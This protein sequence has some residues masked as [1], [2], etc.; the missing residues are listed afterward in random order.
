MA[1][2]NMI[3]H[4]ASLFRILLKPLTATALTST[5]DRCSPC[6]SDGG[7]GPGGGEGGA[8]DGTSSGARGGAADEG[9]LVPAAVVWEPLVALLRQGAECEPTELIAAP[10]R[11]VHTR[12]EGPRSSTTFLVHNVFPGPAP[13][14]AFHHPLRR[15]VAALIQ[16]L[17]TSTAG[18]AHLEAL[19]DVLC[20]EQVSLWHSVAP[21][22][23]AAAPLAV[24]EDGEAWA[25]AARALPSALEALSGNTFRLHLSLAEVLLLAPLG[26]LAAVSA[27][28]AGVWRRN[29]NCMLEQ[30]MNY[31]SI[32]PP[33]CRQMADLDCHAVQIGATQLS[34]A[35]VVCQV[36]AAFGHFHLVDA[37]VEE[38]SASTSSL[39]DRLLDGRALADVGARVRSPIEVLAHVF[40]SRWPPGA[41]ADGEVAARYEQRGATGASLDARQ[42]SSMLEDALHTILKLAAHPPYP[43]GAEPFASAVEAAVIHAL[44]VRP[45]TYSE[46]AEASMQADDEPVDDSVLRA[47]LSRVA[48]TSTA[49]GHSGGAAGVYVLRDKLAAR[50]YSLAYPHLSRSDH[51]AAGEHIEQTLRRP[52]TDAA[53]ERAPPPQV[54]PAFASLRRL[55]VQP[56]VLRVARALAILALHNAE[57]E[58]DTSRA[59][60]HA[61]HLLELAAHTVAEPGYDPAARAAFWSEWLWE[62]GAALQPALG[63]AAQP[64]AS[65]P[66]PSNSPPRGPSLLASLFMLIHG[67]RCADASA[68]GDSG[69][70]GGGGSGGG[71]ALTLC[72]L[73][74]AICRWLLSQAA[75]GSDECA[76]ALRGYAGEAGE[77]MGG[78][79]SREA[80]ALRAEK[81]RNA[82]EAAALRMAK[83]R[84]RF[85]NTFADELGTADGGS[86]GG[87]GDSA[88]SPFA[89]PGRA[90]GD[91]ESDVAAAGAGTAPASAGDGGEAAPGMAMQTCIMCHGAD[92][93]PSGGMVALAYA[94]TSML[95]EAGLD[96]GP[97]PS[98]PLQHLS[99]CGHTMHY[100]CWRLL[101]RTHEENEAR[102]RNLLADAAD[103]EWH[104]AFCPLCRGVTNMVLPLLPLSAATPPPTSLWNDAMDVGDADDD[105][106]DNGRAVVAAVAN[107][108]RW[109]CEGGAASAMER[110]EADET[111][112]PPAAPHSVGNANPSSPAVAS[113]HGHAPGLLAAMQTLQSL[114]T[115]EERATPRGGDEA[116]PADLLDLLLHVWRSVARTVESV[117]SEWEAQSRGRPPPRL[118]LDLILR[119]LAHRP[120]LLHGALVHEHQLLPFAEL[121]PTDRVALLNAQLSSGL[122]SLLLDGRTPAG[123]PALLPLALPG[124]RLSAAAV[125]RGGGEDSGGDSEDG[126]E[127]SSGDGGGGDGGGD[128]GGGAGGAA[129]D[130]TADAPLALLHCRLSEV[131][132]VVVEA[133]PPSS[134][135]EARAQLGMLAAAVLAQVALRACSALA[136]PLGVGAATADDEVD[137]DD[138]CTGGGGYATDAC[139]A[140][141]ASLAEAAGVPVAADAPSGAALRWLLARGAREYARVAALLLDGIAPQPA[142]A[143]AF[144]PLQLASPAAV[145]AHAPALALARRWAAAT[146]PAHGGR[147]GTLCA[148]DALPGSLPRL[149]LLAMPRDFATLTAQLP[150][151][152]AAC[153]KPPLEPALCLLCG[154]LVCAGPSCR[155]ER[156]PGEPRE[157]ECTRHARSCAREVGVFAL[158]HQCTTLLIDGACAT[159]HASLYLDAHDEEDRGLRR[160][161]PLFLNAARQAAL[162]R[163]WL[164]QA[165]PLEVARARAGAT[166]VIRAAYY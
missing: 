127:D 47:A 4:V 153:G 48:V 111:A 71:G 143:R 124:T 8:P 65:L 82:R 117:A 101:C 147:N 122:C 73:S 6:S 25:R 130:G 141:R 131:A 150:K 68:A 136:L 113:V 157:G 46:L 13:S 91:A 92:P 45:R 89:Q 142:A 32:S 12:T 109:A 39:V 110:L 137:A 156:R 84:E 161:K 51:Q 50:R 16:R 146:R 129:D 67:Q 165:V 79:G 166:S 24:A 86:G 29:G 10:P 78:S 33:L 58:V 114:R 135:T 27:I 72:R 20:C 139:V 158:V 31:A 60:D 154:T 22:S 55:P 59:V 100:S 119:G 44:L 28:D 66:Q 103:G 133:M 36:L 108:F 74:A 140:L 64:A 19:L 160:G 144:V 99:V 57:A 3:I 121:L 37:C 151:Q 17:S 9:L 120:A 63:M 164:A 126:G 152:C 69:V 41:H 2:F 104:T 81:R 70:V 128:G 43:V 61:I 62:E 118:S 123:E 134:E 159:Y 75:S 163:L 149:Q 87:V 21:P 7:I 98:P 56:L 85:A 52:P 102:R 15:F 30:V 77:R 148:P 95:R 112:T 76:A 107:T 38:G 26:T 125:V 11:P 145:L 115:R 94:R 54:H 155:R 132:V 53:F 162:H 106:A 5:G 116:L 34:P 49:E 96:A 14:V 88:G 93:S 35:Q 23:E 90:D 83:M 80:S 18:A 40:G 97:A 42:R 138:A 105:D 1:C